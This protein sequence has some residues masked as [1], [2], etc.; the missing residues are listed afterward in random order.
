MQPGIKTRYIIY[1][2]LK[3]IKMKSLKFDDAY[4]R[5]SN[6]YNFSQS[7]RNLIQNVVLNSMRNYI[8][9]NE[10]I[11]KFSKKTKVNS[12]TYFLLL[13]AITQILL[14]NFKDFAVVNT[15]VEIA[16]YKEIKSSHNFV[17]AVLRN[18]I[19]NKKNIPKNVSYDSLPKWFK[20]ETNNWNTKTKKIFI[21]EFINEP[22]IHLVFKNKEYLKDIKNKFIKTSETSI[23]LINKINVTKIEK[24]KEGYWW[25]QD[26]STM[27]PIYLLNNLEGK[28]IA[29]L[30]AAPGGKTFQLI[31]KGANVT[32]FEK[33]KKRTLLMKENLRRL[34]IKCKLINCDILKKNIKEKFDII[35]IDAPC[36][37]IGTIRRNPDIFF[38]NN[39]ANIA[40]L[41]AIQKKLLEKGKLLLKKG[42]IIIYMVC[43][44]F[45]SEGLYQ[46]KHFIK[47]N[48]N[49]KTVKFDNKRLKITKK[50]INKK[51]FLYTI[52]TRLENKIFIDGF[53]AAKLIKND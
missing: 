12:D 28:N 11:K 32:A 38:K 46:I 37:S 40:K 22:N 19:R 49:F 29:D 53:F 13:G 18:I 52:P 7:D 10:I 2:V 44:F 47:N 34:K 35:I 33:N 17:N 39:N 9:L 45:D 21:N 25:I 50:I 48:K 16:K 36:S 6:N 20:E 1:K 27:L 8:L 42:G 4:L 51:G 3:T 41:N 14:L 15:T 43:S 24:Y 23:A 5:E 30:C 26:F 31:S